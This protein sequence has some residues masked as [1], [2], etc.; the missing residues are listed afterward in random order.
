MTKARTRIWSILLVTVLLLSM[1]PAMALAASYANCA[2]GDSCTQHEAAIGTTHYDTIEEAITAAN[3]NKGSTTTIKLLKDATMETNQFLK[4]QITLILDLKG[5]TLTS[6]SDGGITIGTPKEETIGS[7]LTIKNGIYENTHTYGTAIW[8]FIGGSITIEST[9]TV[10]AADAA[11]ITGDNSITGGGT[12]VKVYGTIECGGTAIWGQGP[13]NK[14]YLDGATITADDFGVYHN[15]KFGGSEIEIKTSTI[16]ATGQDGVGIYLGNN[17]SSAADSTRQGKHT[18]SITDSTIEGAWGIGVL[19]TDVTISGENT[20]VIASENALEVTRR[21]DS[22]TDG[23]TLGNLSI[24]GGTFTGEIYIEADEGQ[25]TSS[26]QLTISGGTFLDVRGSGYDVSQYLSSGMT[27]DENGKIIVDPVTA[28]AKIGDVNYVTLTAAL[29][30]AV[31]GETVIL[32]KDEVEL[33]E[34]I[35][36]GVILEVSSG[37]SLKIATEKLATLIGSEGKIRVNAGATLDVGGTKMIG[38]SDA[39]ISLT[40][41]YIDVSVFDS[42]ALMLE[43]VDATAEVPEGHRWTLSK[44]VGQNTTPINVTMDEDTT[45]TVNSTG[46]DGE[47]DGL[48]IANDSTLT[49]NGKIVVNGV[50][51][52]SSG[53]K[54]EGTGTIEVSSNGVLVVNK[55]EGSVGTLANSVTNKGTFVWNGGENTAPT[56]AITLSSGG[57]VYSQVDISAKLSGSK[58]TLSDKTYNDTEYA[59]AW[60]YYVS[61]SSGSSSYAVTVSSAEN[62]K[63]TVSPNRAAKD[64]KVTITVTPDDGY[65]LN[66][67]TVKDASGNTVTVTESNGKYTFKMPGSA[68]TVSATFKA[69]SSSLPFTDVDTGDWFYEAVKYAYDNGMMNGVGNNLFAPGSNLTRGMIAQVLYN[70]EGTP[71]AGSGIFTDV[72][73]GQWYADAVNWAAA[74]DIVGGYGNGKFGPEDDIT[75]E[76]MAQILYNYA[77][78]KGYDVSTQGDLTA[79]NDGAKTSDWALSAMKWAVGTGL[80]QGYNGNLNP[81]GTATRAEVAQ[82]FMNFCENIAK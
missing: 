15:Y 39:N 5:Y 54:V 78:F 79:F 14:I 47:D 36:V 41:G 16:E 67:L 33:E 11:I 9:A 35:P 57:K 30:D 71:A 64:A 28:E 12:T 26:A 13:K 60:E 75:R 66:V 23:K 50:M 52:I 72:V 80:L 76:Q 19:Y 82:I 68:V 81:T 29:N 69:K 25:E 77:A 3:N 73:A 38:G 55:S 17:E 21:D 51:S 7:H 20:E 31:S 32:L 40:G 59:Y 74:N 43:F 2:D 58:R 61:S 1:L 44:S 48:R 70:R 53:G 10:K 27:Q 24:T 42:S 6:T 49:N 63:V 65:V 22:K 34:E 18:L 56:N 46:A 62:G 4:N 8:G 37:Q 45:L